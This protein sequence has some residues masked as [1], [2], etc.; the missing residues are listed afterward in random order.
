[1]RCR[2]LI[3]DDNRDFCEILKDFF[4]EQEDVDVVGIASN[5][6]VGYELILQ[7]QPDIVL[8]DLVMPVSDGLNVLERI[9]AELTK[10]PKVLVLSAVGHGKV[11]EAAIALCADYYIVKPLSLDALANRIRSLFLES[12]RETL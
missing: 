8:L 10:R 9:N 6:I 12:S 2:V 1:M 7:T 11:A 3:V 4:E 5:G